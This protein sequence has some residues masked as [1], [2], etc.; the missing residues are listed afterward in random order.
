MQRQNSILRTSKHNKRAGFAMI[1]AI[2]VIVVLASIMALSLSLTSKS[3]K[4]TA[5][6]YLYEQAVLISKSATEYAL[7]RISQNNTLCTIDNFTVDN[8]YFVEIGIRYIGQAGISPIG[9]GCNE[10]INTL[11]TPQSHGAVLL[12]VTVSVNGV[13]SEPIRYF[14]RTIQKL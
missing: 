5:D 2:T 9:N 11:V 7:L 12:D 8:I 10:Y 1:M 6:L 3:S 14:R 4:Q 13:V